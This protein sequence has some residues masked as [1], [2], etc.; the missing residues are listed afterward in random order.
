MGMFD[1]LVFPEPIDCAQCGTAIP[2]TQTKSLESTLDTYRV[3]DVVSAEGITTGV[4]T[5]R[6]Y[7]ES[8]RK[9]DQKIYMTLW[10]SLI[11]GFYTDQAEAERNLLAVDRADI[12]YYLGQHQRERRR[13]TGLLYRVLGVVNSYADYTASEDK[14][15][16][17]NE[18][19]GFL[20]RADLKEYLDAADPLKSIVEEYRQELGRAGEEVGWP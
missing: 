1:T 14:E 10:H 4:L 6:L 20:V 11:T 2:S 15:A 17:L 18:P 12:L 3:G 13:I 8:C 16:F 5:E 7:C 9:F 19:F